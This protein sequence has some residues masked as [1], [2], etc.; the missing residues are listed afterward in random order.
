MSQGSC[1]TATSPF[2]GRTA[3]KRLS[4][5]PI[6]A[7][8]LARLEF[9]GSTPGSFGLLLGPAGSGKSAVLSAHAEGLSRGGAAVAL[10]CGIGSE[11]AQLFH[12]LA[13]NLRIDVTDVASHA[14]CRVSDRLEELQLEGLTVCLLIDDLDRAAPSGIGLVE[15]LLALPTA[16]L[17]VV[18]AARPESVQLIGSRLLE[19][20][21]LR[22]DLAPWSETETEDYLRTSLASVGRNQ[23]AFNSQAV[24]RLYELSGGLPRRVNQ[25]ADL[26]LLA[27]A[28]QG[29]SR[30]DADTIDA[31]H[32]ELVAAR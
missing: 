13:S 10:F 7:E 29:L 28:G 19:Q 20:A 4:A 16:P 12:A 18:A 5:S 31:V 30:I 14:F 8:A 9:L 1:D 6:H 17:V 23:P 24:E 11:E 2:A 3:A 21:A 25:L 26:A 27:G 15:R 22:I 32:E